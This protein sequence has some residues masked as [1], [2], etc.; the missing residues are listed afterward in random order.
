MNKKKKKKKDKRWRR[1]DRRGPLLQNSKSID[2]HG[3]ILLRLCD[4]EGSRRRDGEKDRERRLRDIRESWL[5]HN[6][7]IGSNE[8][9]RM[10]YVV[11][12]VHRRFYLIHMPCSLSL[13][14]PLAASFLFSS[15]I[16]M[17]PRNLPTSSNHPNQFRSQARDDFSRSV[18]N[19]IYENRRSEE[20]IH[21]AFLS[22]LL[23]FFRNGFFYNLIQWFSF[24]AV[25]SRI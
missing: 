6:S 10:L 11:I 14:L 2:R 15:S 20:E 3:E 13:L 21:L 9:K 7:D 4:F 12:T 23:S 22:F 19:N 8:I 16:E 24:R 25:L 17:A 5:T 1:G 18:A